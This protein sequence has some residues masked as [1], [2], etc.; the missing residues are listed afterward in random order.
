[1]KETFIQRLVRIKLLLSNW[2]LLAVIAAYLF[3][4]PLFSSDVEALVYNVFLS[5][6][7]V[8]SI[9]AVAEEQSTRFNIHLLIAI[10]A[11]WLI[12]S[13]ESLVLIGL[14][15][16]VI[17]VFFFSVVIK[18]I[19]LVYKRKVIDKYVVI[20]AINGYLLLGIGFSLLIYISR[21]YYPEAF[22]FDLPTN[23]SISYDPIYF[24]FVTLTTLGYGDKLPLGDVAK[25]I[26]LLIALAG[27]FY[28]VTVMSFI[29]G[30]MLSKKDDK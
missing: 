12:H 17:V 5:L 21:L 29:V 16:L 8:L 4:W 19:K 6:V 26:S 23:N 27:Q 7:I 30:K 10:G 11:V 3:V 9:F 28:L 25:A 18:F 1:M 20:E 22:N 15:R 13:V 24:S 14:L 2:A